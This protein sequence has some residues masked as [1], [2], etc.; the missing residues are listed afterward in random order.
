MYV[1]LHTSCICMTRRTTALAL[2]AFVRAC[3]A[4]TR[5]NQRR[6]H[7]PAHACA[8][9]ARD[10]CADYI[11]DVCRRC[12]LRSFD[13]DESSSMAPAL[14][15]ST[16]STGYPHCTP[17]WVG[18]GDRAALGTGCG[19]GRAVLAGTSACTGRGAHGYSRVLH[20]AGGRYAAA[21]YWVGTTGYQRVSLGYMR[22]RPL[23]HGRGPRVRC[24]RAQARTCPAPRAAT[25]ARRAPCGSRP[26]RRAAPPLPPR[27]RPLLAWRPALSTRGA[28][29]TTPLLTLRASTPTRAAPAA[30]LPRCCAPPSPPVR[31]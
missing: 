26:R 24:C 16:D 21:Q 12:A 19:V 29:T 15:H 20:G 4:D 23:R 11:A 14:C 8:D 10:V 25:R 27:A 22:A 7:R 31:H 5:S 28:A 30:L 3:S 1:Y 2:Y 9:R 17:W 18:V 13:A 6:R